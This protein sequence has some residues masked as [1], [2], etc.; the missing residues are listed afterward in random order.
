MLP[1][2]PTS[3]LQRPGVA[4]PTSFWNP[5]T[6]AFKVTVSIYCLWLSSPAPRLRARSSSI[7]NEHAA[8]SS[9]QGATFRCH[10]LPK[11]PSVFIQTRG[12]FP[13]P[14]PPL[15]QGQFPIASDPRL[16]IS[17]VSSALVERS[18][19]AKIVFENFHWSWLIFSKT[20]SFFKIGPCL[21]PKGEFSVLIAWF[22]WFSNQKSNKCVNL[23]LILDQSCFRKQKMVKVTN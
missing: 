21:D 12:N 8:A 19:F 6:N 7:I 14:Y 15:S 4:W 13:L 18:L 20:I 10:L 11:L 23:T 3:R 17:R 2:N 22:A 1:L 9:K 16:H 5:I